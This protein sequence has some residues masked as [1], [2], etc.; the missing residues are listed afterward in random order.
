ML[1]VLTSN[2]FPSVFNVSWWWFLLGMDQYLSDWP[3][4][5][6]FPVS[7]LGFPAPMS[8]CKKTKGREEEERKRKG[9]SWNLVSFWLRY[10]SLRET[11]FQKKRIKNEKKWNWKEPRKDQSKKKDKRKRMQGERKEK[12]RKPEHKLFSKKEAAF[13]VCQLF[14]QAKCNICFAIPRW[15]KIVTSA[16]LSLVHYQILYLLQSPEKS[17]NLPGPMGY[18]IFMDIP[19]P[20]YSSNIHLGKLS[21]VTHLNLAVLIRGWFPYI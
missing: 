20:I 7:L 16:F 9:F 2:E 12:R 1:L 19:I 11:A 17:G 14:C 4:V 6:G 21:H 3:N 8:G 18:G 13:L 15:S 10:R 5:F